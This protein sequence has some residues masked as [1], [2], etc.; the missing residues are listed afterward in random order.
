[1]EEHKIVVVGGGGVGK[2]AMTIRFL[3]N[4]FVTDYDPTIEECYRKQVIVENKTC[5]LDI[6]DTGGQED[7]SSMRAQ[8]MDSGEGFLIIYSI[9]DA[10]S[11]DQVMNL[12]ETIQR[13]KD[14][15]V[16]PGVLCGNKCDLE[17]QRE[18]SIKEGKAIAESLSLSFFETSA[19]TT[20]NLV[21]SFHEIVKLIRKS[22]GPIKKKKKKCLII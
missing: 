13:V 6:L 15:D 12:C 22:A 7:Y 16:F 5:L 20:N 21:E 18:V 9:I 17:K 10:E 1:M 19:K 3:Q 4:F 8:Y 11:F 14:K 2:S